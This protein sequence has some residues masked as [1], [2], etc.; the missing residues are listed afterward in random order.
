MTEEH[1]LR[2]RTDQQ[3]RIIKLKTHSQDAKMTEKWYL[4]KNYIPETI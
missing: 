4:I 3:R 1:W 2:L